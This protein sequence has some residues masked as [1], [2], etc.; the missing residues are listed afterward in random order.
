MS[1]VVINLTQGTA[2]M[3]VGIVIEWPSLRLMSFVVINLTQGTII[4]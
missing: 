4:S 1:F 2:G 3:F